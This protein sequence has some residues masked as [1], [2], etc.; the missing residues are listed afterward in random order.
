[1]WAHCSCAIGDT[2][3]ALA[4]LEEG[5]ELAERLEAMSGVTSAEA[6][7]FADQAVAALA[8]AVKTGWGLPSELTAP[9]FDAVRGRDDF[10]KLLA[11]LNAKSWPKARPTD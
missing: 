3:G 4:A 2:S 8:D 6:A 10:K 7:A 1:M 11:E 9:D 5:R